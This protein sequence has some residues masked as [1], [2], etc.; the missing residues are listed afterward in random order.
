M[1]RIGHDRDEREAFY[2]YRWRLSTLYRQVNSDRELRRLRRK[3]YSKKDFKNFMDRDKMIML[4]ILVSYKKFRKDYKKDIEHRR[5]TNIYEI[6]SCILKKCY[7]SVYTP[8]DQVKK[9]TED[10]EYRRFLFE[11]S[12]K[13]SRGSPSALLT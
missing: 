2:N 7:S 13:K 10:C 1:V 8:Y 6:N 3:K 4:D 9:C 12:L 5:D 11:R